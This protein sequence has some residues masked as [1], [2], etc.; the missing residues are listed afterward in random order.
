MSI[1]FVA[2]KSRF[3]SEGKTPHLVVHETEHLTVRGRA[4]LALLEKWGMVQGA[5]NGEDSAGRAKIGLM[6]VQET[7]QRAVEMVNCAFKE[8]EKREWILQAPTFSEM[9][10][11]VKERE[12]EEAHI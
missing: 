4:V 11:M 1:E 2:K 6:P 8:L 3:E 9:E 5:D 7:V 12:Q 10:E